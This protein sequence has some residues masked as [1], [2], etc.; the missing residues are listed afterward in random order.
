MF[1]LA[2]PP[3]RLEKTDIFTIG[4]IGFNCSVIVIVDFN[5]Q[6]HANKTEITGQDR[7]GVVHPI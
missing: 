1:K 6:L 7:V 3:L 4:Q 5:Q 2:P